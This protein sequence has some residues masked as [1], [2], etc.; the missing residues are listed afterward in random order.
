[1][2]QNGS[3]VTIMSMTENGTLTKFYKSERAGDWS[4]LL[5][6]GNSTVPPTGVP[7]CGWDNTLCLKTNFMFIITVVI[8]P[9]TC[10]TIL[11]VVLSCLR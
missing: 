3:F 5:W 9:V 11:T 1:M 6:P 7:K 2:W 4:G 8:F 10:V